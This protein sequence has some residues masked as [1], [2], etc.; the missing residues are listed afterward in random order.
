VTIAL[1]DKIRE[2]DFLS[3]FASQAATLVGVPPA[4]LPQALGPE[5][6]LLKQTSKRGKAYS[7][8]RAARTPAGLALLA[9][10]PVARLRRWYG[11]TDTD[12]D[13]LK[14]AVQTAI[15][16][17]MAHV[18]G[19]V[20]RP[21][22]GDSD[23]IDWDA[24]PARVK[25]M[26]E[27]PAVYKLAHLEPEEL[28]KDIRVLSALETLE[29]GRIT[30]GLYATF[31]GQ[32][33]VVDALSWGGCLLGTDEVGQRLARLVRHQHALDLGGGRYRS[34]ISEVVRVLQGVKQRFDP[35]D[36]LSAPFLVRSV[37]T[38]F[39][40]RARLRRDID[41]AKVVAKVFN[42]H[43]SPERQLDRARKALQEGFAEAIGRPLEQVRITGVQERAMEALAEQYFGQAGKAVVITGNTGSGKTEAALL[44][45]LLGALEEKLRG[46]HGCKILLVYPRQEL[47]KNQLQRLC[48]YLAY[49]NRSLAGA[50]GGT[51]GRLSAGIVFG[52]TPQHDEELRKGSTY[53]E[54][55]KQ[56]AAGYE[57]PYFANDQDQPVHLR[58]LKEG[59]GALY[60]TPQGFEDGG[61]NLEGFRATREAV[62][63]SPPDVLVITT[64]MLHRWLMDP[65]ANTLFG[66]SAKWN[67]APP[68]A[69]PRALVFDEIHLYDTIHGAQIGLLIRR[70]RHR[71]MQAM[72]GD[73]ADSW[74]YPVVVGMSATIGNP[75]TFWS[76]L[77]G[78][79]PGMVHELTPRT[80]DLESAQGREYFLFIRP[81][82]YSRGKQI[83]DASVAI[84]SIMAIAHNMRRRGPTGSEP[85]KYR[86]IVFQDSISKVKKLAIEFRDAESGQFLS[87]LRLAR[88]EGDPLASPEFRDAEY[89]IFDA[90]DP[91]QYS[92]HRHAPG[93]P[94]CALSSPIS[95]VYSGRKGTDLLKA[96]LV[97]STS[98]L[99]VGY[100]DPSLQFVFQ[101]HA[102]RNAASFVQRKGRAGRALQ[103]RPLTAVT[104]SRHSY[105]DAFYYQNPR[106]LYD[107]ED[108][109]PPLNVGNYFVQQFQAVALFFDELTRTT[110]RDWA[111]YP[112]E[113]SW[114]R[115]AQYFGQMHAALEK[116]GKGIEYAYERV[117]AESFR[118]VH[119]EWKD[120]LRRF[121]N[122]YR[123][124]EVQLMLKRKKNLLKAL[125]DLPQN[126]FS[127][128]NLPTVQ[129]MIPGRS[130]ESEWPT[131]QEDVALA[132][133]ELAPGKVS[134]RYGG[135]QTLLW[136]PPSTGGVEIERYKT[137]RESGPGPF[138]PQR[139]QAL[140]EV[141]GARWRDLLPV[142][143]GRVYGH[144]LP[145][146]F[147]RARYLELWTFGEI[148]PF[149]PRLPQKSWR[150]WGERRKDGSVAIRHFE[151][152]PPAKTWRRISPESTSYPL[153][154]SVVRPHAG[155]VPAERVVMPPLFR[156]WIDDLEVY[157]GEVEGR[158][159]ALEAWE[160][161]YG[162]EAQVRMVPNR[163]GDPHAQAG[164]NLVRYIG[165]PDKE[166]TL[167]GYDLTTEGLRVRYD[168]DTLERLASDLVERLRGAPGTAAHLEDEFL[169]Y[170]LK[171]EEWPVGEAEAPLTGFDRRVV[172]D[173]LATLSALARAE[174]TDPEVLVAR[175]AISA[176]RAE[177]LR[178]LRR[179]FW[180][181]DRRFAPDF[182]ERLDS[183]LALPAVQN[184]LKDV[185]R[186]VANV[187]EQRRYLAVTLTHSMKHAV[188]HLFVTQG[189]TRDEE[190]GSAGVFELTHAAWSPERD[191]YVYER[192]VDGS[193]AARL[194]RDALGGGTP[195]ERVRR[196]WDATL[197]CPV[198]EEEEFVRA[199]LRRHPQEL[200]DFAQ[201]FHEAPLDQRPSPKAFLLDLVGQL[202]DESDGPLVQLAG[203]LTSEVSFGAES[204]ARLPLQ[205]ELDVLE[206]HLTAGLRRAPIPT[207][208]AGYA[209]FRVE[210]DTE[211]RFPALSRL[212]DL[213]RAHE[214][215]MGA[216]DPEDT[217]NAR[218]RFLDQ[219]EHLTL[220]S[221]VDACPA[222]LA[223]ECNLGHIE[224]TRH[225]LSR[226]YL[227]LAHRLLSDD[228]TVQ[229]VC[230][231]TSLQEVK[232]RAKQNGGWVIL[233]YDERPETALLQGVYAAGFVGRSRVFDRDRL[234]V[235]LVL[236]HVGGT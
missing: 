110:R 39:E 42:Q 84:Q 152:Q 174:G 2:S 202:L 7:I 228:L 167:Y 213:Y 109:R 112:G 98:V 57:L 182:L 132:F 107:P 4:A 144:A 200:A 96:D 44:P 198:G 18:Q 221:C 169:R 129:V 64:E 115:L 196:W 219:L 139:V 205:F 141:W 128:I 222:C 47:A 225:L 126:L 226:R 124:R 20:M 114:P 55:W 59:L 206:Q 217:A 203:I 235:R 156:G 176:T 212:W 207:E 86:G 5:F 104:L 191:F 195:D 29:S 100:D 193:G 179:T 190:V 130:A 137:D 61:W 121:C 127:T 113:V 151:E 199:M 85:A 175:L 31:V 123:D 134:R 48:R 53:R 32:D 97:F 28:E 143:L 117:T 58:E 173:L 214:Q 49:V 82:T 15:E 149:K 65:R 170:L 90:E 177:E 146:R 105:R 163:G 150:W 95:P 13:A 71:V 34:R 94:P 24:R 223:S 78:L 234:E 157:C 16:Q 232:A 25:T 180:R 50:R 66:L 166:P 138:D 12:L 227:R 8:I 172:A 148:D 56:D 181:D 93:D 92:A 75:R 187:A 208:L 188:R 87:A 36:R 17:G 147:Y 77:S 184:F 91:F 80:D 165:G 162:A 40:D 99:E 145:E 103:D 111:Y 189:S 131:F 70:L 3:V 161:H 122:R 140:A 230:G 37:R 171:S 52:D 125:P 54:R 30:F 116:T 192:N 186:R 26:P 79:P 224:V 135:S 73:K 210:R 27:G 218:A 11:G 33:E 19:G 231:E 89:W 178:R 72:Y 1:I 51:Q 60:S 62:L 133:T 201:A 220:L 215:E 63:S 204:V 158:R 69:P 68:F 38:H 43:R 236:Q 209:S 23:P 183:S 119:P 76:E 83:G 185:F 14:A 41:F 233:A 21:G 154:F 136:R 46:V 102:P 81:E 6:E 106:L 101:H 155:S 159:S 168:A 211:G 118:R 22:P 45:L 229:Y 88:P 67:E 35:R 108:Y 194:V 10:V 120:V 142:H 197:A 216:H 74:K 160:V 153:S 9:P 164:V